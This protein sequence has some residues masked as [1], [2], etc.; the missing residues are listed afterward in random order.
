MFQRVTSVGA[1]GQI[2]IAKEFR[3]L[4]KAHPNSLAVQELI[5]D[6]L[7]VTILP[8]PHR[9]SLRGVLKPRRSRASKDWA[10]IEERLARDIAGEAMGRE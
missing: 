4:L 7:V 1:R 10:A 6:R 8:A 9:R 3:D 5:G 2:T